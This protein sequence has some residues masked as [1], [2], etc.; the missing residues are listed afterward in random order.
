MNLLSFIYIF[1]IATMPVVLSPGGTTPLIDGANTTFFGAEQ[2]TADSQLT[3]TIP[4]NFL[5][6]QVIF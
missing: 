2:T 4:G 5:S 3:Q 6:V 1:I